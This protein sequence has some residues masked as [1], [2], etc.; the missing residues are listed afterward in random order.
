M[1]DAVRFVVVIGSALAFFAC[2]KYDCGQTDGR[3][4]GDPTPSAT[5]LN[6]CKAFLDDP[7]CGAPFRTYGTCVLDHE[8]CNADG[9]G[10]LLGASLS[11]PNE[12]SA[13]QSCCR[14]NADAGA[15]PLVL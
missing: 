3:C 2:S 4:A 9:G 15:C 1:R 10:N 13:W 6:R 11:C 8:E 12:Y 14:D 7:Q 5:E